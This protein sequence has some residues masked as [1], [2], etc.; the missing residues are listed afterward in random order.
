MKSKWQRRVAR[1][2]VIDQ[3]RFRLHHQVQP[4]PLER[5]CRS[6][7]L[8]KLNI[9]RSVTMAPVDVGQDGERKQVMSSPTMTTYIAQ[10]IAN[11][12]VYLV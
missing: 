3:W 12:P 9:V 5:C 11:T 4:S 10:Q 6:L 2:V 1:R 7:S 8:L